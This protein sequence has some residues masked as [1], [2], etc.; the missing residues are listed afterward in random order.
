MELCDILP[1]QLMRKQIP[2]ELTDE[3]VNFSRKVSGY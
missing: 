1:G 3:M 2:T